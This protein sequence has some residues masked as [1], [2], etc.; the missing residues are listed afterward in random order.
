MNEQIIPA[1]PE[2]PTTTTTTATTKEDRKASYE[3]ERASR[4]ERKLERKKIVAFKRQKAEA[5]YLSTEDYDDGYSDGYSDGD[6]DGY[7]DNDGYWNG[8]EFV[9]PYAP[10]SEDDDGDNDDNDDDENANGDDGLVFDP[11]GYDLFPEG[12]YERLLT[13]IVPGNWV[14]EAANMLFQPIVAKPAG[15]GFTRL[16]GTWINHYFFGRANDAYPG[17]LVEFAKSQAEISDRLVRRSIAFRKGLL[18]DSQH[19]ELAY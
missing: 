2:L 15:K 8:F 16:T 6:S 5:T 3:A 10:S 7:S 17:G 1:L 12:Y 11:F 4:L 18:F 13:F 9:V 19:R 14:D